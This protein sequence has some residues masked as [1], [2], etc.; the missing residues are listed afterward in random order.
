MALDRPFDP[1]TR[2]TSRAGQQPRIER[3]CD[4]CVVGSG[5]SG[6]SAA[7]EAARA[8]R[9]VILVDGLPA[10]GGQAVN[11]IIGMFCGLYSPGENGIQ[12]THGIADE[13]LS[14]LGLTGDVKVLAG[15]VMKVA[16]YNEVALGR[17]VEKKVHSEGI[18]PLTGAII[19]AV[20]MDGRRVRSLEIA[21]RYGDV[22]VSATGF[23][24]ATG[25]AALTWQ[26]GLECRVHKHGQIYGSQMIV[27]EDFDTGKGP[28]RE[29][30]TSAI[31]DK[32]ER[33]G[34]MRRD[35]F[36]M[37]YPGRNVAIVNMTHIET[38]LEPFA[39]AVKALEGKEQADRVMTFLRTEFPQGYAN[40]RVRA[41]G[42]PGIRQTR[43]IVGRHHLTIDE[44]RAA[45]RFDDAIARC[46][47]PLEQHHNREG[48]VWE[49]FPDD[50]IH[51]VPLRCLTVD[52]ADNL[53][54][55]GRCIDAD[56]AALSSVRVM[57]PCIAMGAA[58]AHALDL[59]GSGSVHQIDIKALQSRIRH[60]LEG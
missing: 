28:D 52:G 9:E 34:M 25:D 16:A 51:T 1:E 40:A 53:I 54:A 57:G 3:G 8:G 35:G 42:L 45:T 31:R 11:S 37:A 12:L 38:P 24:D 47:W 44:V 33:Y 30:M 41:Y 49:V 23:V 55:V 56:S 13:I 43:W 39:A 32:G 59:A 18:A 20:N 19:R 27:I 14:E 36:T 58:A 21:T 50:H 5:A 22:R 29:T 26:A 6:I 17:W 2:V 48:Y 60:N 46:S 15:G 4:I 10:L 7:V